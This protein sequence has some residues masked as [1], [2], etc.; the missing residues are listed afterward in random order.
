VAALS[1]GVVYMLGVAKSWPWCPAFT[2]GAMWWDK[3][4]ADSTVE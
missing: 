4:A 2:L 1:N 3:R